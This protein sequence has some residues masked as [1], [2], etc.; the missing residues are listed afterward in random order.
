MIILKGSSLIDNFN[1]NTICFSVNILNV[2]ADLV[3]IS[4]KVISVLMEL[5]RRYSAIL[6]FLIVAVLYSKSRVLSFLVYG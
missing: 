1:I 6:Y 3:R 2:L 5:L 4:S